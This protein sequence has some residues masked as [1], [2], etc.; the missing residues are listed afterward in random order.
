MSYN[1]FGLYFYGQAKEEI[2]VFNGKKMNFHV[3]EMMCALLNKDKAF[4]NDLERISIQIQIEGN[5]YWE[6]LV[7]ARY[8]KRSSD[9]KDFLKHINSIYDEGGAKKCLSNIRELVSGFYGKQETETDLMLAKLIF[10]LPCYK[11]Y[12]ELQ[13]E[14]QAYNSGPV[15]DSVKRS[16]RPDSNMQ[17]NSYYSYLPKDVSDKGIILSG[18]ERWI[19]SLLDTPYH[20]IVD[21][22]VTNAVV[23]TI[24]VNVYNLSK[25]NVIN[26]KYAYAYLL[27]EHIKSVRYLWEKLRAAFNSY[28][29]SEI[30]ELRLGDDN[31]RQAKELLKSAFD[32]EMQIGHTLSVLPPDMATEIFA[33]DK[34]NAIQISNTYSVLS[35]EELVFVEYYN[36]KGRNK[37]VKRCENC[38]RFFVRYQEKNRYCSECKIKGPRNKYENSQ[39]TKSKA[40]K[41]YKRNYTAYRAWCEKNEAGLTYETGS[42]LFR[43]AAYKA[44]T[45]AEIKPIMKQTEKTIRVEIQKRYGEWEKNADV[46]KQE[47]LSGRINE[48]EYIKRIA[49]P[50]VK[51]RS[52]TLSRIKETVRG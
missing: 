51:E 42:L 32:K 34:K 10:L 25:D 35:L 23:G 14:I 22:G 4:L 16:L 18:Y 27:D 2:L 5:S 26:K 8:V 40:G 38:G 24:D 43:Y 20:P 33:A 31:L 52:E 19:G 39:F 11:T 50:T 1:P 21:C 47:F 46:A 48:D 49:L 41:A 45:K 28:I 9:P 7:G 37:E 3:G 12:H 30:Y 17:P 13:Q 6:Q 44:D 15:L 29:P 36:F